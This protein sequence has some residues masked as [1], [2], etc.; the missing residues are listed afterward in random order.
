M[1]LKGIQFSFHSELGSIY[2]K[3]EIDNLFFL[4]TEAYFGINRLKLALENDLNI[5]NPKAILD[6]LELL[7]KEEPIQY[8]LGETEFFGLPFKVNNNVLIPRPETEE[9][10]EWILNCHS[11]QSE[12]SSELTILDIGTGS[13]CIAI[14][15]A[16]NLP[17]AQVYALDVSRGALTIAKQNAEL[18]KVK[19]EFIE[20]DIL[21]WKTKEQNLKFDTIVSNPPYVRM[22]EK[23]LMKPNVLDNEPHLAL[24]VDDNNQ[25][26]FYD[27]I[28]DFAKVNLNENGKLFFEINEFLGDKMTDLLKKNN[29]KYIELRQDIFKKDRMVKGE[30]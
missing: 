23:E 25:L 7:K 26:L 11:E 30:I 14:S 12:E 15:L 6:A 8:V 24:F 3:E 27:T 5:E 20:S 10:V 18:N 17:N 2:D 21:S 1:R 19:V 22:Q 9:L 29:Y 4:L 28:C 16:K 13:G